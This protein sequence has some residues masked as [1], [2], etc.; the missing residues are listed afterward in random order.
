MRTSALPRPQS[1]ALLPFH[2]NARAD[3]EIAQISFAMFYSGSA[4]GAEL[5]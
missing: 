4:D 1:G 5:P 3:C 2:T